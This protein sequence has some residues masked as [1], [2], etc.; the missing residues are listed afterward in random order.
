LRFR[1]TTTGMKFREG[2][3]CG[4]GRQPYCKAASDKTFGIGIRLRVVRSN[5]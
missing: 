4:V 2:T 5:S 3:M 1:T